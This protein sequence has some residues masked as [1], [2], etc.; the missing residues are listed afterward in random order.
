MFPKILK[1]E[2]KFTTKQAVGVA[3]REVGS[4]RTSDPDTQGILAALFLCGDR[5][6]D[7]RWLLLDGN[8][9]I[10][11][12]G[13]EAIDVRKQE[14]LS[15]VHTQSHLAPLRRHAERYWPP[16]L[17][18]FYDEAM[19]GHE[20]LKT[21]L[22]SCYAAQ[23]FAARLPRDEILEIDHLD[24]VRG[25]VDMHGESVAGN[26]FQD[27]FAYMLGHAGYRKVFLNPVGIPDV[28]LSGLEASDGRIRLDLTPEQA[29]RLLRQCEAT[30][31]TEL[32]RQ[33]ENALKC[34]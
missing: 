33:I 21:A 19:A 26:L 5:D 6:V 16:F 14:F 13:S 12:T 11:V 10:R 17:Q 23:G 22:E 30:G 9:G 24:A 29:T 28:E 15:A 18:A 8:E 7:G 1:V 20:R 32:A 27:I 4:I 31:E 3:A 25:L 2:V 34:T